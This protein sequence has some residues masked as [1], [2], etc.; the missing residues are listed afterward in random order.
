MGYRTLESCIDDLE[1]SG[2][3]V[4][5]EERINAHLEA[6]EIH[7]RVFRAGAVPPSAMQ[8]APTTRPPGLSAKM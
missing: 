6:A 5:I 1:Y 3:L 4:R 7:R 8:A 2:Q